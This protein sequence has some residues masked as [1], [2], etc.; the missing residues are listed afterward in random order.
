MCQSHTLAAPLDSSSYCCLQ[1]TSGWIFECIIDEVIRFISGSLRQATRLQRW[2]S[3]LLLSG[4]VVH[5]PFFLLRSFV[6]HL[7]KEH[8]V[9]GGRLRRYVLLNDASESTRLLLSCGTKIIWSD[10][11]FAC[12]LGPGA[13]TRVPGASVLVVSS[14]AL[15]LTFFFLIGSCWLLLFSVLFHIWKYPPPTDVMKVKQTEFINYPNEQGVKTQKSAMQIK[16]PT[17]CSLIL[18]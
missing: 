14:R 7:W 12:A 15:M 13:F 11:K 17:I 8:K 16:L 6:F 1:R 4:T 9:L 5:F 3:F 10:G 2:R 18:I